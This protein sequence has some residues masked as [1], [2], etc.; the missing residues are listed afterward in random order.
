MKASDTCLNGYAMGMNRDDM[1]SGVYTNK[2]VWD[3]RTKMLRRGTTFA[4]AR[5]GRGHVIIS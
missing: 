3:K 4:Y 5:S 1:F 2:E